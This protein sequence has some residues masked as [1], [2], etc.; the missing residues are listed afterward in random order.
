MKAIT[1]CQPWAW[2]VFHGKDIENRS[3]QTSH[4]GPLAIH[5][6]KS[7]KGLWGGD[8]TLPDGTLYPPEEELV[9][10]AIL[11][12]VNLVDIIPLAEARGNPWAE[13]PVCWVLKNP[14][15]LPTPIPW[16]GAQWL[17]DVPDSVLHG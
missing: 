5:A 12:V 1:L 9:F 16:R 17:F 15:L 13:G 6:S 10:G 7:K 2:A 3:R 8:R 11:G 14:R 4:R